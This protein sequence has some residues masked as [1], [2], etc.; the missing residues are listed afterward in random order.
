MDDQRRT[1]VSRRLRY[2]DPAERQPAPW[3]ARE[4]VGPDDPG[5]P[6]GAREPL[7]PRPRDQGPS[8]ARPV[9]TD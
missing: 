9:P 6:S 5:E 1:N 8:A 3:P 2:H 7:E 4:D